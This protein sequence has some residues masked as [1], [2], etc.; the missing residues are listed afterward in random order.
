MNETIRV[1]LASGLQGIA[2]ARLVNITEQ[3]VAEVYI[4]KGYK[5]IDAKSILG[6]ISLGIAAN[7][8]I[9]F[10]IEGE[11]GAELLHDIKRYLTAKE[12]EQLVE[13]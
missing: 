9:S 2:A 10:I 12:C 13:V 4:E 1:E 8:E 3:Y 11:D 5:K 6:I 7:E